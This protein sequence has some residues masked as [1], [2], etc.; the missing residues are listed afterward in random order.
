[1]WFFQKWIKKREPR[2]ILHDSF[3]EYKKAESQTKMEFTIETDFTAVLEQENKEIKSFCEN[4]IKLKTDVAITE[5]KSKQP[6]F[7]LLTKSK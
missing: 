6:R 7:I 2:V 5:K 4:I 3:L 1:M